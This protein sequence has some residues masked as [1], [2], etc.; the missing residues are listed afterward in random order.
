MASPPSLRLI[1]FNFGGRAEAIRLALFV[2]EV[3]FEDV[4]ITEEEFRQQKAN[5]PLAA[6]PFWKWMGSCTR[7]PWASFGMLVGLVGFTRKNLWQG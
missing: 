5:T 7:S 4:R 2:G 3:E 6:S 1:Y